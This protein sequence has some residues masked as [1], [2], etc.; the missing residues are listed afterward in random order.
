MVKI[1]QNRFTAGWLEP[2]AVALN[3]YEAYLA[4]AAEMTNVICLPEGGFK[5]RYSLEY[6]NKVHNKV[7]RIVGGT[8]VITTPNGG[9]G[10]NA[11]DDNPATF[12]TTTT[13]IGVNNPY[14]VVQ[15]D[16][17]TLTTVAFVDVVSATLSSGA[18]AAE[19]LIQGSVDNVI[20]VTIGAAIPMST[21]AN[22]QRRRVNGT[23]RYF[24]FVRSGTTNLGTATVSIGEFN[25]WRELSE[26]SRDRQIRYKFNIGQRY[27]LLLTD[28]NIAVYRNGI[29]Q[30]DIRATLITEDK[31]GTINWAFGGDK[32]LIC[33]E[34]FDVQEITR[35]G[36][37]DNWS[38]NT[39]QPQNIPYYDFIPNKTLPATTLTPDSVI[40]VVTLTAGANTFTAADVNQ[41]IEGNGGRAR[42]TAYTS[43]TVVQA[44]TEVPFYNINPITANNWNIQRGFEPM[45]S[46]TRGY[47]RSLAFFQGRL[48][49][50]GMRSRPRT[51]VGSVLGE[52]LDFDRGA[53]RDSDG[54]Y[55]DLDNEE[56]IVNLLAHRSLNL[57]TSGGESSVLLPRGAALTPDTI[58]FFPQTEVGSEFG[59]R[60]VVSNG[61]IMFVQRGGNSIIQLVFDENQQAF[62]SSNI[63][64]LASHLIKQPVDFD[65]RRSTSADEADMLLIVNSDGTLTNGVFI[66]EENVRGFTLTT[67]DGLITSVCADEEDIYVVVQR[68]INGQQVKYFERA[69]YS[70]MGDCCVR[71]TVSGPTTVFTDLDHLEGRAVN[72]FA[73]GA[74]LDDQTVVGGQITTETPVNEYVD[75]GLNFIPIVKTLPFEALQLIGEKM[76]EK[77]RITSCYVW[78]Y[79]T[80]AAVVNNIPVSFR[81]YND[82]LLDR[83]LPVYTGIHRVEGLRGWDAY[84]QVTLTQSKPTPLTVLAMKMEASV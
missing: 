65:I 39:W 31:L 72:V 12:L 20:W 57:F 35:L 75:I 29:F 36:A 13:A 52:Y 40:G 53:F 47:I 74:Y 8:L 70:I 33:H 68:T 24:R 84:G 76:G 59:L 49:I 22:T 64:I 83:P 19:F 3:D 28:R 50:G 61:V 80:T 16:L 7:E 27:V 1:R 14:I 60:P 55:R 6:L 67:T 23:Y 34:D 54:F 73:D 63:S 42:I 46:A 18:N 32:I 37:D 41:I 44:I 56:P 25:V 17:G 62:T 51:I 11:N 30:T 48:L 10:A 69:N 15:Y 71:K 82:Q 2:K 45:W 78:F 21:T 38:I 5:L 79:Q 9:I 81:G 77:K 66:N 4:G 58:S 43:P 26:I